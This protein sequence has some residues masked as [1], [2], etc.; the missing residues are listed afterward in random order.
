LFTFFQGLNTNPQNLSIFLRDKAVTSNKHSREK[1]MKG[2]FVIYEIFGKHD[3][4]V[5]ICI[6]GN[7]QIYKL[8]KLKKEN[9][10]NEEINL[11]YISSVIRSMYVK[12]MVWG[13]CYNLFGTKNML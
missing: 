6:P 12:N 7:F 2:Q 8:V 13:K 4:V 11:M 10:S 9:I 3:C 5:E 1:L